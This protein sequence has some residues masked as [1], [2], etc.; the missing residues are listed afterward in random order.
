MVGTPK[1]KTTLRGLYRWGTLS[2]VS[3]QPS[4]KAGWRTLLAEGLSALSK[5]NIL[6]SLN[7]FVQCDGGVGLGS[8]V[9]AARQPSE[10][11]NWLKADS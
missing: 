8:R 5:G 7:Y 11:L 2:A 4:G 1:E 9:K 3:H 6:W 10:K